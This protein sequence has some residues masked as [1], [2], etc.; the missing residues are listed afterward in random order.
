MASVVLTGDFCELLHN[1]LFCFALGDRADK[2]SVICHR[3]AHANVFARSDFTIVTLQRIKTQPRSQTSKHYPCSF[4]NYRPRANICARGC[5][6]N[7]PYQLDCRLGS[8]F[9]AEGDKGIASVQA[10]E[11]VHHQTQVPDRTCLLKQGDQLILKEI[12]GDFPHK[13]LEKRKQ[14]SRV[15][16]HKALSISLCHYKHYGAS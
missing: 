15:K 3:D 12:P 7:S 4:I 1:L 5:A 13:Y 11:W 14:S 8:L 2:Q 9:S 6:T 10:T 16:L